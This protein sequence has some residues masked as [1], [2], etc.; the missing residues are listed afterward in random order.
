MVGDEGRDI[1]DLQERT[2][3]ARVG[4]PIPKPGRLMVK[5][6]MSALALLLVP[7]QVHAQQEPLPI[8]DM[9]MHALPVAAMGP[10][11]LAVCVPR[12]T[13]PVWDQRRPYGATSGASSKNPTCANPV[14]SA[15]TDG[16]RNWTSRSGST[17]VPGRRGCVPQCLYTR[18]A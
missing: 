13:M 8:I 3:R 18:I 15:E 14:W 5:L 7:Y 16:E 6:L 10:P 12:E 2:R 9:H 1:S 4:A 17:W 11:P